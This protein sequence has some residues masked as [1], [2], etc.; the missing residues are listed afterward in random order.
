M[1][2]INTRQVFQTFDFNKQIHVTEFI[3]GDNLLVAG[4][5]N[6][7][8]Q[9]SLKGNMISEIETSGPS[10]YSVVWQKNPQFKFLSIAGASNNIDISTNFTYKDGTLNF[11]KK[12]KN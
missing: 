8:I 7:L 5:S 2:Q 12:A 11:Y 9:Y 4:D 6:V 3:D 10:V 1:N